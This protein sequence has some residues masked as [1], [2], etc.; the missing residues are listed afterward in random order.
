MSTLLLV[1]RHS[2]SSLHSIYWLWSSDI[3]DILFGLY[4]MVGLYTN[5]TRHDL[6]VLKTLPSVYTSCTTWHDRTRYYILAACLLTE[7]WLSWHSWVMSDSYAVASITDTYY[8]KLCLLF[9]N[10][11]K[12]NN[13]RVVFVF[14]A[15]PSLLHLLQWGLLHLLQWCQLKTW[16]TKVAVVWAPSIFVKRFFVS[17]L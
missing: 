9:L 15:F 12:W 5:Q 11:Y 3:F 4:S 17:F 7:P 8:H 14:H 1:Y 6:T 2:L 16:K 13:N 10:L